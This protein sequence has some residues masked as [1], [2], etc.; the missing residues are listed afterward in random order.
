MSQIENLKKSICMS[1]APQEIRQNCQYHC[2]NGILPDTL[3]ADMRRGG[4]DFLFYPGIYI[5]P[6]A[7]KSIVLGS[8][9]TLQGIE[10]ITL[11]PWRV[12]TTQPNP[13]TMAVFTNT[14]ALPETTSANSS[15]IGYVKTVDGATNVRISDIA[16]DGYMVLKLIGVSVATLSRIIINNYQGEYASGNFCNMGYGNATASL[17]LYSSCSYITI[18]DVSIQFSS[19]HGF[20]IHTGDNGVLSHD[21]V[22]DGVRALYC[23]CGLLRGEDQV[24]RAESEKM[25][26]STCGYGYLDWS[27][28][29]DLCENATVRDVE[30]KNCTAW[31]CWK[32]G[33][34]TEPVSSSGP[35]TGIVLTNCLAAYTGWRALNTCLTPAVT[36]TKEGEFCNYYLQTGILRDCL[37]LCG[38]KAGYTLCSEDVL[39]IG[40][41]G[42]K[43]MLERCADIRSPLGLHIEMN[44]SADIRSENCQFFENQNKALRLYGNNRIQFVNTEILTADPT[45]SP[46]L[47]G[48]MNREFCG[49]SV[50]PGH[51]AAYAPGGK[52]DSLT[53]SMQNSILTAQIA[54]LGNHTAPTEL[55]PGSNWNGTTGKLSEKGFKDLSVVA[56][57]KISTTIDDLL[58]KFGVHQEPL[59][60]PDPIPVEPETPPQPPAPEQ[61]NQDNPNEVYL[62]VETE[63]KPDRKIRLG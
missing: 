58:L 45:Q 57:D 28:G 39:F 34:Y 40:K 3:L 32:G 37:S 38:L 52:Y 46:I 15:Q 11:D 61:N 21:I 25:M 19:H 36:R 62:T 31:H 12:K 29:F 41:T 26:P 2:Q 22:L 56:V 24:H 8:N 14:T 43:I 63:G 59:N 27:V 30:V 53:I 10:Q 6:S 48:A 60:L 50:D 7:Q 20:A 4:V 17:W 35:R 55:H 54:G 16:L 18:S 44:A 49:L 47:I 51:I 1:S 9:T 5:V 33:F 42:W 23:G 13:T